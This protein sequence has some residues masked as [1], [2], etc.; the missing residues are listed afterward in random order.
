MELTEVSAFLMCSVLGFVG[1]FKSNEQQQ[2][3]LTARALSL[4]AVGTECQED[5]LGEKLFLLNCN[6][7]DTK[8][9]MEGN[10]GHYG[11]CLWD[12]PGQRGS[13]SETQPPLQRMK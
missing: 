13:K 3:K 10:S 8:F 12:L 11:R 7:F 5:I 9:M 1:A 6:G 2:N 4:P